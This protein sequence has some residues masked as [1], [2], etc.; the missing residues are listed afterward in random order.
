MAQQKTIRFCVRFSLNLCLILHCKNVFQAAN[1]QHSRLVRCLS[2]ALI[3]LAATQQRQ[4]SS[5][6]RLRRQSQFHLRV[7]A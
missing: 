2:L 6:R 4:Q 1:Q 7:R 5:A 3:R